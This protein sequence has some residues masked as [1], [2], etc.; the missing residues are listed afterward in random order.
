[1]MFKKFFSD[2]ALSD[3]T[4]FPNLR[5]N[6]DHWRFANKKD[7]EHVESFVQTFLVNLAAVS[8]VEFIHKLV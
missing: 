2:F 5:G 3:Y 7:V 8:Y 6:L 4:S 1:M